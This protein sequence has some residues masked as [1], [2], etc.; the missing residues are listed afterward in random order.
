MQA[1]EIRTKTAGM[2]P[3]LLDDLERLVAI[4]SVAFPG[5]PPE[6]V[7]QM[8]DEALGLLREAGFSN[9]DLQA[10]PVSPTEGVL[11]SYVATRDPCPCIAILRMP[12]RREG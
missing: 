4:P 9:A 12:S 11:G 3:G 1:S 6:P 5:Y 2:M 10:V 7:G 8:A